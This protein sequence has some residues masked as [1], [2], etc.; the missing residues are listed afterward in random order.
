MVQKWTA[1]A[2]HV[3][4][5]RRGELV[6]EPTGRSVRWDDLDLIPF[7]EG[8]VNARTFSPKLPPTA[9]AN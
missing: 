9:S 5:M 1:S 2:T 3:K 7:E 8:L 6:V 4:T